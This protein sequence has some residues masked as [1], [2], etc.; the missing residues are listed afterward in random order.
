M[1][2]T[3]PPAFRYFWMYCVLTPNGWDA[4]APVPLV[5]TREAIGGLVACTHSS[6]LL[7]PLLGLLLSH[8][9]KKVR[10]TAG[11]SVFCS[12]PCPR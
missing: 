3:P 10:A 12:P 5:K 11:V 2:F 7:M 6:L 8:P 4:S 1:I 9:T